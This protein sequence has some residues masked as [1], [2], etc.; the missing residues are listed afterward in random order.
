MYMQK[1]PLTF[2]FEYLASASACCMFLGHSGAITVLAQGNLRN[3]AICF[4]LGALKTEYSSGKLRAMVSCTT[5]GLHFSIMNR[6]LAKQTYWH[7][8][9]VLKHDST[10]KR[11]NFMGKIMKTGNLLYIEISS[12]ENCK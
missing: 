1:R 7:T 3:S 8:A 10:E 11:L 12:H 6:F 4:S 9:F 5:P 2:H